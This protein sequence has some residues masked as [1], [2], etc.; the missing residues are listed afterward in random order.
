MGADDPVI[1]Y[2]ERPFIRKFLHD[3]RFTSWD[4][5][6]D[7]VLDDDALRVMVEDLKLLL[8]E[9][10]WKQVRKDCAVRSQI[11]NSLAEAIIILTKVALEHSHD[12]SAPSP[13][14]NNLWGHPKFRKKWHAFYD[15]NKRSIHISREFRTFLSRPGIDRMLAPSDMKML[16]TSPF[17]HLMDYWKDDATSKVP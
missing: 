4:S 2:V 15:E 1:S 11:L 10:L 8:T 17:A 12:P 9:E 3:R 16:K 14:H 5:L 6:I 7:T 13:Y